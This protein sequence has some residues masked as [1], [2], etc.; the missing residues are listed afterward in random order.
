MSVDERLTA[1]KRKIL[2]NVKEYLMSAKTKKTILKLGTEKIKLSPEEI[3]ELKP[4]LEKLFA[5]MEINILLSR[6]LLIILFLVGILFWV[7]PEF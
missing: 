4:V 6:V 5:Q 3:K 2:L 7:V 1:K